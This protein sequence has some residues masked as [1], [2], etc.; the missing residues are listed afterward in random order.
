MIKPM[1]INYATQIS[2]WIYQNGNTVKELM[3]GEYYA[4]LDLYN[5]LSGYFCFGESAQIP[6]IEKEVY[7]PDLLDIGLGM[8]PILCG[9][10]YGYSFVKSGLDFAKN[11][12]YIKQIR[13]TVAVFNI[14][15]IRIYEKIGFQLLLIVTHSKMQKR[16]QVMTY[17]Y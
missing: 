8:K 16:F 3:N 4:Y 10:G 11:N 12:F 1:S 13:L 17:T 5:N 15:A 7:N 14:R 2:G 6:T 9:K